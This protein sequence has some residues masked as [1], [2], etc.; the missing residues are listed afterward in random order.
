M[1]TKK[2]GKPKIICTGMLNTKGDEIKFL[3]DQVRRYGGDARIMDLSLGAEVDWADIK[4]SDVL[5]ANNTPKDKVFKSSRSDAIELVGKAGAVKITQLHNEGEVDGII[6]WAGSVGTSVVTTA[7]RALPIGVPKF[8]LCTLASGDVHNW[9]GNKDIYIVNP[10]SEKGINRVTRKIIANAAAGIV[11]MAS[12]GEIKDKKLR[13]LV[14]LTLYGTTTPTASKCAKHMEDKNWDTI[15]IHQVGTG[16]TME[17]LIRSGHINA[18]FEITPGELSNIMFNSIYGISK[19]WEG[20]RLTAA[21]DMGIPQIVC[22]GGLAQCAFGPLESMPQSFLDDFKS[23]SRVSYRN[24]KKPYVH[25]PAVTLLPPTLDETKT[26]ALEIIGKLNRTKGPTALIVPMKGWSAYDQS[27]EL[28][29][30]ERGWAKENGDGPVWLPDPEIPKWSKRAVHMWSV[31]TEHIDKN[32]TNLDLIKCDMHLLD[33]ELVDLL[34]R[35]M[36]DMLDGKWQRG[37]Y[38]DLEGVV[39]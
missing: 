24:S 29:T 9:L 33:D 6:S 17:D 18:V 7:M 4:L 39:E 36:D 12:V 22:P 25:N 8:M 35:C 23:G 5:S 19:T 27:A 38:R 15:F 16:A 26:L 28:A 32:N 14:A 11:S 13:P 30:I 31:F 1:D 37:M 20:E 21:S 34:N 2:K 10:I 3:A